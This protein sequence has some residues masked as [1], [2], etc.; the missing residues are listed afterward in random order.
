MS[1][2]VRVCATLGPLELDVDL[3]GDARP[4][5][6]V[7]PNGAGKTTL[8]RLI[9][10]AYRPQ[11]GRIEVGG[12]VLFDAAAAVDLPPERRAVGYVPQGY[13][14]FPHLGVA[15]NVAFGLRQ[16][17][18]LPEPQV[19]QIVVDRLRDVGLPSG[20]CDKKP[21]ELSGGMRKRVGLARALA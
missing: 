3:C 15:D 21:A 1:W 10:G 14:L 20:V 5:A 8:L 16:N 19:R 4:V 18:K 7:G 6:L 12:R 2:L 17:K 9:A 11:A 13:G